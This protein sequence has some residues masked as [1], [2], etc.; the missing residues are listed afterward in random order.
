MADAETMVVKHEIDGRVQTV[1]IYEQPGHAA[2]FREAAL[3]AFFQHAFAAA[4]CRD[5]GPD[6]IRFRFEAGHG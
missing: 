4:V 3:G 1:T 5:G 6:E 2:D